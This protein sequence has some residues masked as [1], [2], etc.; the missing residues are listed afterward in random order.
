MNKRNLIIGIIVLIALVGG[1]ALWNKKNKYVK[2][3]NIDDIKYAKP[4]EYAKNFDIEGYIS[5]LPAV[6]YKKINYPVKETYTYRF[7][8]YEMTIDIPEGFEVREIP[9]KEKPKIVNSTS[10]KDSCIYTDGYANIQSMKQCGKS[11]SKFVPI[12]VDRSLCVELSKIAKRE[13]KCSGIVFSRIKSGYKGFSLRDVFIE[14]SL[15]THHYDKKKN[16]SGIPFLVIADKSKFD[17]YNAYNMTG[18]LDDN[19]QL[20]IGATSNDI[21]QNIGKDLFFSILDSIK[22]KRIKQR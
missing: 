14:L 21:L 2:Y 20:S 22:I 13:Y 12:I 1:V 18:L 15:K 4:T 8:G 3:D 11:I 10:I 7:N 9:L 6:K 16:I 5:K 19:N 17:A